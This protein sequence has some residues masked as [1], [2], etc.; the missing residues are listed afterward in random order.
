VTAFIAPPVDGVQYWVNGHILQRIPLLL[1]DAIWYLQ[2]STISAAGSL[3]QDE[4]RAAGQ[5]RKS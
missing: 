5:E 1:V 3:Q 4:T 2:V